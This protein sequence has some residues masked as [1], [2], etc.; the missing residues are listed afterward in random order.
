VK[1]TLFLFLV[2]IGLVVKSAPVGIVVPAYFDPPATWDALVYAATEVPL[3]VI[4]NPDSGP[5]PSLDPAYV[6]GINNLRAAGAKVI[7][8][9]YSGMERAISRRLKRTLTPIYRGTLS[10]AFLWMKWQTMPIPRITPSTRSFDNS[11]R[12]KERITS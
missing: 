9:V 5:G 1:R 3:I 6:Q 2:M 4:A 12:L 11:F 8:Y 7:G 10:M